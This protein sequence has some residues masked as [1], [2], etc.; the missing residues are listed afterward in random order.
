MGKK[1]GAGGEPKRKKKEEEEEVGKEGQNLLGRPTFKKLENGRFRCVQTGHEL[2]GKERDSYAKTKHCRLGLIDSALARSK[3]PLNMFDQDPLS[4]SKLICKLTG[5]TVN[6]T[7]EHIWKH[8]NG[9]RFLSMLEKKEAEEEEMTYEVVREDSE[10]KPDKTLK[11]KRDSL[12]KKKKKKEKIVEEVENVDG[13]NSDAKNS[14]EKECD[15]EEDDF[16][17]PPVG[18][19]WDLDK[20]GD[21]WGSDSESGPEIDDDNDA[22]GSD[23]IGDGEEIDNDDGKPS[24]RTKSMAVEIESS[25]L[26]SRKK[27]SKKKKK[28]KKTKS[29]V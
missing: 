17:I 10:Q 8:I 13:V 11:R 16:W 6:K 20:G 7:E 1:E 2:P 25:D 22:N 3:P 21:R 18:D 5:I 15:S 24:K 23:G 12:K 14:S 26:A 9:K 27:K 4:R 19:R 29:A 28:K